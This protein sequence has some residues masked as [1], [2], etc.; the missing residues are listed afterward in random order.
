M[1]DAQQQPPVGAGRRGPNVPHFIR[2]GVIW[3]VCMAV[4]E[5]IIYFV[6]WPHLPP[7]TMSDTARGAQFDTM[8]LTM[9]SAPVVIAV[10]EYY[11][12]S[13][14]VWR[15]KKGEPLEDGPPIWGH[16]GVQFTWIAVSTAIVMGAFVFGTYE[17]IVPAGA[18]GGEGPSPIWT[19][20]NTKDMLT[21][22]VIAQQW[23]FTYRYPQFGG[24]ESPDLI[25]P[26]NTTIAFHVTSLDVIHSF[27]AYQLGVKADANPDVDNVAFTTTRQMGRFIVRCVELCGIWHGSMYNYGYV[28]T[29]TAFEK[30][31]TDTEKRLAPLTKLLPK[32][33]W[34]YDPSTVTGA[35]TY[36]PST[37]PFYQV[38]E[39]E[40]GQ[41]GKEGNL[42]P[43]HVN[44]S[45]WKPSATK[46]SKK[47]S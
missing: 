17:L 12:Y 31:A 18:G 41:S 33:S 40:Y 44:S 26:N 46:S 4:I 37:D 6:I 29:P 14:I 32:F 15:Q 19:P 36:Y 45:G 35:D 42:P 21:V 11:L 10:I 38:Y 1:S 8:V 5:P 39:Y 20:S 13:V 28:V 47:G 9:L 43:V 34:T 25:V 22:Q 30:W 3:V 7:G 27:W 24:F 23:L 16:T 2:L